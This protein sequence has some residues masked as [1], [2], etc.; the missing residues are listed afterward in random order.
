VN[1]AERLAHDPAMR[2]VVD[3][4][5]LD[6][7]AASTSQM[8]RFETTWLTSEPNLPA[9]ADLSGS[10]IDRVH[11]RRSQ[12][13]IVFAMDRSVSD[14]HG[15]PE[16]SAY[17]RH[18]GCTCYHSLFVFNQFGAL[19][20]CALRPGNVQSADGWSEVLKPVPAR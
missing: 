19:E 7:Q 20:R 10:W 12:A 14:T 11:A 6:R 3:R 1:D 15:A 17:N 18:F 5:S 8:G 9:L 16:D 13:T 2:A 4:T